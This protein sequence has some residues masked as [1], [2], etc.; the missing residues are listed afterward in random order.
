MHAVLRPPPNSMLPSSHGLLVVQQTNA[1]IL[2][3]GAQNYS[4]DSG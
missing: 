4:L 3:H 1:D 2:D